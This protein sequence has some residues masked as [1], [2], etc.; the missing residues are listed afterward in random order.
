MVLPG[1]SAPGSVDAVEQEVLWRQEMLA[2]ETREQ[3]KK[4]H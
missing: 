2:V 4:N 1:A 3:L